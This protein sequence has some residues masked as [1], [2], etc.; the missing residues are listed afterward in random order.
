MLILEW[1]P[2]QNS[3]RKCPVTNVYCLILF[4]GDKRVLNVSGKL[5]FDVTINK[6]VD[7]TAENVETTA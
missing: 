3:S 4:Y 6:R 1:L 2:N 5:F 7:S